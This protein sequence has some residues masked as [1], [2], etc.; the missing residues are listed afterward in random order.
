M[1][2][3]KIR[4]HLHQHP[5]LSGEE[6]QTSA[7]VE[8]KLREI[9]VEKIHKN[10]SKTAL[11]AEIGSSN[12]TKTILFRA[13]LDALPIQ[14]INEDLKYKSKSNGIAHKCGH[15]GHMTILLGL[16]QK[17]ITQNLKSSRV[18]LLFQ[19][20]EENGKGAKEVLDSKI[21]KNFDIDFVF[22][23]H[24]VPGFPMGSIISKPE[25]FTP[26]VESLDIQLLGK[27]SHAGMPEKGI[28]PAL[29]LAKLIR[30]FEELHQPDK[31]KE[32]YFL[33][34][35][36]CISMGEK[37]YGTTPGEAEISYTFRAFDHSFFESQKKKIEETSQKIIAEMIGLK[38]EF[39]WKE[40]FAAN[41]NDKQAYQWIKKAAEE[42]KLEFREKEFPFDWGEDFGLFTQNYP[43]AMF[44]LGAGKNHP[45]LHNPDYDFPD[46]LL[47]I[48][49]NMF[50]SLI[51]QILK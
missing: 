27:T 31:T 16:A 51:K 41:K 5:E 21:F 40:A 4:H 33:S 3:I 46:E 20:S 34:S 25:I 48:G 17:I 37:A 49:I 26:S 6:F 44:G 11:L 10:F 43:G 2:L 39:I 24:N 35:P 8:A 42:N 29:V 1:D 30:F 28:N 7:F 15:D 22:A 18:L 14:E 19:A 12:A 47:E 36:I 50:H 32:N 9:G 23:L 45:E 13:E 38:S